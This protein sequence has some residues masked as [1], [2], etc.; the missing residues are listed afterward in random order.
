M[1][2]TSEQPTKPGFYWCKTENEAAI[3]EVS[4]WYAEELHK[5]ILAVELIGDEEKYIFNEQ[6]PV[7][8]WAGPIP[9]PEE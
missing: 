3:V 8:L 6:F 1:K 7:L 2:W 9:E 4:E 5:N